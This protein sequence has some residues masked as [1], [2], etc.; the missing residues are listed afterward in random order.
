MN[1]LNTASLI[2]DTTRDCMTTNGN[3]S[4]AT[5]ARK[6]NHC[7]ATIDRKD[8]LRNGFKR[9]LLAS[10]SVDV[11]ALGDSVVLPTDTPA[12]DLTQDDGTDVLTGLLMCSVAPAMRYKLLTG[13]DLC[14][15]PSMRWLVRGVLPVEGLAALYGPS[16][17][18]KSFLTLSLACAV[19]SGESA[20]FGRRISQA[21][22]TYVCL[23]GEAGMGKRV[24]AWSLHQGRPLPDA[25]RFIT[26]PFGLLSGDVSDLAK[27]VIAGGGDGGMVILDTLNRA[28][29]GVDENSSTDMGNLIAAAKRLQ[30]L[31]DGLVLLV[32][33]TGKDVARGM[34]GHSSLYAALDG[35][36]EVTKTDNRHAW[37]VA[38]SKDDVTGDAHPF[39]LE[40]VHVG[41]DDE[42][43]A[44][45][46]CVIVAD[47]ATQAIQKKMPTLGRNQAI[48]QKAL[49]EPLSTSLE[50]EKDGAPPGRPCISFEDALAIVAPQILVA[51][52]HQKGRAKEAID[53]LVGKDVMGRH[54]DWL[55]NNQPDQN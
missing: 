20:W 13:A 17:C 6:H 26:Q 14:N 43:E 12:E 15:A 3:A 35:A 5:E 23:E 21:P 53:G 1:P 47:E 46:S 28:A 37:S 2:A 55:W 32:H 4:G 42:A 18:G 39:K 49:Q 48:A 25:L 36:V 40:I 7:N 8:D 44:I 10:I 52:K 19:A 33:H 9:S 22:V 51:A 41:N 24:K 11:E 27:A 45:T 16:G 31:I 30:S 38:K 50:I 34:R 29:P 54:G